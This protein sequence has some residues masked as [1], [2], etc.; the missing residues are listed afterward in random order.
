M[1]VVGAAPPGKKRCKSVGTAS[2]TSP[3]FNIKG[4][5]SRRKTAVT[6]S[7][8][9][10][11]S[12]SNGDGIFYRLSSRGESNMETLS[13]NSS[14]SDLSN[15]FAAFQAENDR[16]YKCSLEECVQRFVSV[17][18]LRVHYREFHNALEKATPVLAAARR[19]TGRVSGSGGYGE[20]RFSCP[21]VSCG[22]M[23]GRVHDLTRHSTVHSLVKRFSCESCSAMFSRRL[24]FAEK[25][26]KVFK[27][28]AKFSSI[29]G[30]FEMVVTKYLCFSKFFSATHQYAK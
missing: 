30:Y 1:T 24:L 14:C 22:K 2:V 6:V 17:D 23:F 21:E 25:G 9:T 13:R 16:S 19:G 18:E 5:T 8:A 3:K 15:M 11:P 10:Q 12:G 27:F 26:V 20:K 4:P 29:S 28:F 7:S